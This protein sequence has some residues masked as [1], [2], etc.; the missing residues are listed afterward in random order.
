MNK[1]REWTVKELSEASGVS[2]QYIGRLLREGE[3]IHGRKVG[4]MW[5]IPDSEACKWLKGRK[6]KE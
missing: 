6:E 3:K 4:Y 2:T 1:K 5:V